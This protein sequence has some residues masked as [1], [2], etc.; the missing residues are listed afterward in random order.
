MFLVFV[1]C[2]NLKCSKK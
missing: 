2:Q 1:F